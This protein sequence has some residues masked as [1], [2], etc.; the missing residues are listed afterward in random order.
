[1]KGR[2]MTYTAN[3]HQV[4]SRRCR[5]LCASLQNTREEAERLL[6]IYTNESLSGADADFTDTDIA[7][8]AE[9]VDVM[10]LCGD[11]KKFFENEAVGT[12]DRQ[13]W[14]TPFLQVE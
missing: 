14:L 8:E 10:V 4:F 3:D 5:N 9:H 13:Q 12:N 1:M 2:D 7:L 6:A 11:I